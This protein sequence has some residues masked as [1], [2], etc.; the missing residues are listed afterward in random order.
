MALLNVGDVVQSVATLLDDP[1]Q[2]TYDRDYIVPFI[3]L[4]WSD[5]VVNLAALGLQYSEDTVILTIPAYTV[6]LSSQ[7][8][9][10]GALQ[11]LM[12]PISIEWKLVGSDDTTY[13][14]TEWVGEVK[15]FPGG[16][17][18]IPEFAWEGGN[19]VLVPS[20]Q[21]VVA[22]IRYNSMSTTL[23]DPTDKMVR[24]VGH[25]VAYEA[26][27]VIWAIRG[28]EKLEAKM[29]ALGAQALDDFIAMSTMR[30]QGI[31]TRVPAVHRRGRVDR[32]VFFAR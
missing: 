1:S 23:V 25:I 4:R 5:I 11:S 30:S 28:N 13:D 31:V 9:S 2:S 24:G 7:M 3:N 22:R 18:G 14:E 12:E 8:I 32:A 16:T 27:E 19:I 20:G 6:S 17:V 21:D 29:Q 26:A 10:G 15:D